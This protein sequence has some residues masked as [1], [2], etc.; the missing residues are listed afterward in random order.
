MQSYAETTQL[1]IY[2]RLPLNKTA[3]QMLKIMN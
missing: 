1:I 2:L 3:F